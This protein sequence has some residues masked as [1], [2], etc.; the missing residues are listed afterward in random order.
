MAMVFALPVGQRALGVA[1]PALPLV[2]EDGQR[3]HPGE[4]ARGGGVADLAMVFARRVV[5]PVMLPGLNAPIV[6]HRRQHRVRAGFF[7]GQTEHALAGLAG[8]LD[9]V[10]APQVI[11]RLVEAKDLRRPGQT[12]RGPLHGPGPELAVFD[13]PVAF[14]GGVRLRGEVRP[15]GVVGLWRGRGAGCP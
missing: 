3:A 5:A 11:H 6:A 8:G 10:P 12:E 9:D 15:R 4:I 13:P 14:I 2:E 1:R 7:R